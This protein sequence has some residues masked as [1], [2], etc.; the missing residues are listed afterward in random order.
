MTDDPKVGRLVSWSVVETDEW[1]VLSVG[2]LLT[3]H[4]QGW[5]IQRDALADLWAQI[6]EVLHHD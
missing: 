4:Y 5:A 1:F 6:S 2:D 3:G